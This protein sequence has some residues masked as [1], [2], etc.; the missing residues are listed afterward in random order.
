M[1]L[2]QWVE[3]NEEASPA[4]YELVIAKIEQFKDFAYTPYLEILAQKLVAPEIQIKA[5]LAGRQT[6]IHPLKS[7]TKIP[8]IRFIT[9]CMSALWTK[10]YATDLENIPLW[11]LRVLKILK[12]QQKGK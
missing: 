8:E 5:L 6:L 10:D 11:K 12:S 3:Q 7:A 4:I 2:L 9:D 1:A